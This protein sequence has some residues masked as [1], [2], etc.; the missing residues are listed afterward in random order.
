[1]F[2]M[3][4]I[5]AGLVSGAILG[6]RFR[7]L[8]LAAAIPVGCVAAGIAGAAVGATVWIAVVVAAA[9]IQ[10]GFLCGALLRQSAPRTRPEQ[11]MD[12]KSS[13]HAKQPAN[14]IPTHT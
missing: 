9:S 3:A 1:M 5:I 10:I 13:A 7:I 12:L 2:T 8:V 6:A 14:S 4:L 11:D